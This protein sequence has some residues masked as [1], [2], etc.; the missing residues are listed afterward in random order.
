MNTKVQPQ[1]GGKYIMHTTEPNTIVSTFVNVGH[2]RVNGEDK[3]VSTYSDFSLPYTIAEGP[4]EY[5]P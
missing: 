4:F 1:P 5:N 2:F 3:H